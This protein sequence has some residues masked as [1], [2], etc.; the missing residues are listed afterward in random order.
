MTRLFPKAWVGTMTVGTIAPAS[1]AP[2]NF[3]QRYER[4]IQNL[5][6]LGLKVIEDRRV[7]AKNG[8]VAGTVG[9][10]VRHI[11]DLFQNPEVGMIISAIG[12]F[13]SNQLLRHIDYDLIQRNPKILVG[14]S[15]VT[16][17]HMA[18]TKQTNLVTFYGPA[19]M[20]Q[21]GD[22]GGPIDFTLRNFKKAF[23]PI[24]IG[25]LPVSEVFTE[26]LLPW[27]THDSRPKQMQPN[28]GW[29]ICHEGK[30]EGYSL[31]ANLTTLMMTIATRWEP[32]WQDKVLF[33]E[34]E[35]QSTQITDRCLTHLENIGVFEKIKGIV[36]GRSYGYKVVDSKYPLKRILRRFGRRY[37]IPVIANVDFG[38]SDPVLT[39]PQLIHVKVDTAKQDVAFTEAA[40]VA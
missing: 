5:K 36:F 1:P 18:I 9:A 19:I 32:I 15:D 29:I 22:F 23:Q 24:P 20:P 27:G 13:N 26:E 17:L 38:H 16:N 35:G 6:A 39:L 40:V 14:Y 21:F 4:G 34:E 31:V 10:R 11:H 2:N 12:G 30:S 25:S 3:R 8:H 7:F 28:S 37:K 33:L